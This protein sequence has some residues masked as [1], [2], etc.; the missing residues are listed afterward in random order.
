VQDIDD[1]IKKKPERGLMIWIDYIFG[2]FHFLLMLNV[3]ILAISNF[4][5]AIMTIVV[6]IILFGGLTMTFFRLNPYYIYYCY[7]L[8]I[9][10]AFLSITII[11]IFSLNNSNVYIDTLTPI[12]RIAIL[13]EIIYIY[14]LTKIPGAINNIAK[15]KFMKHFAADQAYDAVKMRQ[16]WEDSTSEERKKRREFKEVLEAKYKMKIILIINFIGIIAFT[17]MFFIYLNL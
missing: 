11:N 6:A 8:V 15:F 3:G 4:L 10:G 16:Y 7:S 12:T 1:G 17:T 2:V 5:L 14:K 9:C 13:P